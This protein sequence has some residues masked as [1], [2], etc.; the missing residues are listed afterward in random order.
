M[1]PAVTLSVFVLVGNP[2]ILGAMGL[3]LGHIR[4]EIMGLITLVGLITIGLSTYMIIYS[5]FLYERLSPFLGIFE[6]KS[7]HKEESMASNE[8][9][10]SSKVLRSDEN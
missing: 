10:Y 3:S 1:A 6:R 8:N 9:P 4:V 5:H 7:P 2:I